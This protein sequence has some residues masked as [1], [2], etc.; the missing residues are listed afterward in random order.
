MSI[1]G[2]NTRL[3]INTGENMPP[4]FFIDTLPNNT[5]PKLQEFSSM[6]ENAYGI[7][8]L[9]NPDDA[10]ASGDFSQPVFE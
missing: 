3:L 5:P 10:E 7:T 9:H 2:T 1:S 8:V 4:T 6:D